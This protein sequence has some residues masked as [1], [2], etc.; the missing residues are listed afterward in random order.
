MNEPHPNQAR[1]FAHLRELPRCQCGKPATHQVMSGVNALVTVACSRCA[2]RLLANFNS[3]RTLVVGGVLTHLD[4]VRPIDHPSE[5][6][7]VDVVLA[8]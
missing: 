4:H 2:P 8:R 6:D 1:D 7:P 5:P 3:G